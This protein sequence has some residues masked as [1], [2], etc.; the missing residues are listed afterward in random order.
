M[1]LL[2]FYDWA[3]KIQWACVTYLYLLRFHKTA[4]FRDQSSV[5]HGIWRWLQ[6]WNKFSNNNK[7]TLTV[8]GRWCGKNMVSTCKW[9]V[10]WYA[11][12]FFFV[13]GV[14][15]A[16]NRNNAF[17][18]GTISL[19]VTSLSFCWGKLIKNLLRVYILL[20]T[21]SNMDGNWKLKSQI[22]VQKEIYI[23]EN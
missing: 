4:G 1:T 21:T 13:G 3:L 2:G 7:N 18:H 9:W 5:W 17:S 10:E 23:C 22:N 15:N 11:I 8:T 16:G 19:T 12:S 14:A 20:W 6:S